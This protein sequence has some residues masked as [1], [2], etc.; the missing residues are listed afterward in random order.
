VTP[1]RKELR[2][3]GKALR[4]KCAKDAHATWKPSAERR[5][6]VELIIES[7]ADRMPQLLPIRYGRMMQSPFAFYRGAAAIMAAD[8]AHTPV[9]GITV[10]ACGDC[11]LLNFGGFATP[12]RNI[13]FGINDFDETLPAPWEWDVKR[14]AASCVIAGQHNGFSKAES[15]EMAMRCVKG[16]R[17]H[18]N[19]FAQMSVMERWYQHITKD[20]VLAATRSKKWRKMSEA[21]IAKAVARSVLED[22]FP[23]LANVE[24]GTPRIRD[25]PPLIFHEMIRCAEEYADA[26]NAAFRKYR[27][28]LSDDHRELLDRFEM[29]DIAYKV[30]GVGSVGTYCSILLMMAASDDA[31]FLQV[32]EARTSVLEPYAGKSRY[33]NRG[34][35][36]VAGQRLMQSASDIFLGWT[37]ESGRHY[38]VRQLRDMKIKPLVDGMDVTRL[39]RYSELCG[40]V[41]ARAHAKSGDAA[42]ISGYLGS[43][44]RFD[45]AVAQFALTYAEQNELDYKALLKAI[46]DGRIQV[47]QE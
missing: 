28:T 15:R 42:M 22:D 23:K 34:Q 33:A 6:P 4:D 12:E 36:V 20:D 30:V 39:G 3:A 5:D 31:L 2:A 9:T 13:I 43:S 1:T 38:Y 14:L 16:Y 8:L 46:Q 35:R 17:E 29:K 19:D 10:Q 7:A 21:R 37:E 25:N 26:V 18:M 44:S 24:G 27:Q 45:K 32:K 41:L 47:L 40:W 11:H